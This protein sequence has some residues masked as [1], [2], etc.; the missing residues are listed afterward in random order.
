MKKRFIVALDSESPEQNR[1]VKEEIV[2]SYRLLWWHWI[3]NVWLLVDENGHLTAKELRDR[4][5][6]ILPGVRKLVVE[7]GPDYDTWSGHGTTQVGGKDMFKW[8]HKNWK[9]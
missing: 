5:N 8:I 4:L 6:N 7:I 2:D 9:K 3:D 1:A